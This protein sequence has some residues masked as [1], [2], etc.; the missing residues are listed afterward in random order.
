P[1]IPGLWSPS[2]SVRSAALRPVAASGHGVLGL[3]RVLVALRPVRVVDSLMVVEE[4]T[5]QPP[6]LPVV[7]VGGTLVQTEDGKVFSTFACM[8]AGTPPVAASPRSLR[9]TAGL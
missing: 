8:P 7:G 1:V 3:A 9:V 5:F 6:M 2:G 4:P